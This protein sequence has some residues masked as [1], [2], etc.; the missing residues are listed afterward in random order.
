MLETLGIVAITPLTSHRAARDVGRP[1]TEVTYLRRTAD[2][3]SIPSSTEL[4]IN[5]KIW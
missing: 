2:L 1:S 4:V 3:K 5:Q